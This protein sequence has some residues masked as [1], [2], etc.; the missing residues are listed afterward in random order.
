MVF[1]HA[2]APDLSL[3]KEHIDAHDLAEKMI[4]QVVPPCW[5]SSEELAMAAW[6]DFQRQTVKLSTVV[7][8]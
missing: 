3:L 6:P 1:K 2:I 8:G 7:N 4:W 5:R